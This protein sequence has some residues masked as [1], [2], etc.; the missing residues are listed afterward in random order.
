[1][2]QEPGGLVQPS[3]RR[4]PNFTT[5]VAGRT[6]VLSRW[7]PDNPWTAANLVRPSRTNEPTRVDWVAG[8]CMMVRRT[9]F[10]E[11]G[12]F[13]ERFFMYWEDADLC[14]RLLKRGW[15]TIY[16]PSASVIHLTG[17][18][19]ARAPLRPLI[20]FHRS[21]FRYFWKNGSRKLRLLVPLV[22]LVLQIRLAFKITR[23]AVRR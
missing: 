10:V 20:E 11:V 21:A 3:A 5:G 19:T 2:V 8:S 6:G 22:F 7:W 1:M 23:L 13:D 15:V 4:F 18:S 9:A 17:R 12:G 16:L 14:F